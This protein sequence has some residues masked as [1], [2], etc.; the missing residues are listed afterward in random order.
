[1]YPIPL[2]KP[3]P[4][5]LLHFLRCDFLDG[6]RPPRPPFP[7]PGN[8]KSDGGGVFVGV[9]G[10]IR[11]TIFDLAGENVAYQLAELN[12]VAGAGKA[13]VCHAGN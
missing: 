2:S 5:G 4:G 7:L 13:F 3:L 11:R 8:S 1:M 10:N 12:R 9:C 6:R